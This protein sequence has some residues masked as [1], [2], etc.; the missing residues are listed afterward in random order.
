[1]QYPN[2]GKIII[3]TGLSKKAIVAK[4]IEKKIHLL[5]CLDKSKKEKL[6]KAKDKISGYILKR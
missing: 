5:F 4:I 1:M 2:N 6:A 3:E